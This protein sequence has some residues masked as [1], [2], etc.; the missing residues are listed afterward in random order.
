M[1]SFVNAKINLGL[2]VTERR[3]DGYH[4]LET[5][6]YPVG[7]Y[8]GTPENPGVFCDVLEINP[9]ISGDIVTGAHVNQELSVQD[10]YVFKGRQ[11]E[12]P[13]EKNLVFRAVSCYREAA[14][15][16]RLP[17]LPPL[18]VTLEKHI[19]D[20]AGLGGG[21]ADAS[22]CLRMLDALSDE[23]YGVTLGRDRL[24]A[25]ALSLGADCPFFI[26]NCPA[27]AS[28]VGEMLTP[29]ERF[30]S[31]KWLVIA[32]PD[33]YIST[34]EAFSCI[35]PRPAPVDLRR[36]ADIPL[37]DW[38]KKVSNDF[39][40]S[41]CVGHPEID[42]LKRMM[43]ESGAQYAAMSGSGSSVFGIFDDFSLAQKCGGRIDTTVEG[44]WLLKL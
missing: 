5:V 20:G 23:L 1:I 17:S 31:G 29:V 26:D 10:E 13:L 15:Y 34:R 4:N 2:F 12:C 39:E 7:L 25:L 6:F 35:S 3:P 21:S 38:R 43:Y 19:P 36:V 24:L 16:L 44:I 8:C 18:R 11:I 32:K 37:A 14:E 28:G 41:A 22:F 42:A 9:A 40:I 33:V 27:F 30:L